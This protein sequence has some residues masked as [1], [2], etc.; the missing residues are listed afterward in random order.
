MITPKSPRA[1]LIIRATVKRTSVFASPDALPQSTPRGSLASSHC[2]NADVGAYTAPRKEKINKVTTNLIEKVLN[3]EFG[4]WNL[5][6][7]IRFCLFDEG[8]E[9]AMNYL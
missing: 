1:A 3:L 6:L 4:I 7:N 9:E 8:I 2:A 5:E